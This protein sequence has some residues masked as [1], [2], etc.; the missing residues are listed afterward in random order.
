MPPT[1]RSS[2]VGPIN[3]VECF[4]CQEGTLADQWQIEVSGATDDMHAVGSTGFSSING[5][6]IADGLSSQTDTYWNGCTTVDSWGCGYTVQ[7]TPDTDEPFDDLRWDPGSGLQYYEAVGWSFW[8]SK[9]HGTI[10]GTVVSRYTSMEF[11]WKNHDGNLCNGPHP[12]LRY[13]WGT[14]PKIAFNPVFCFEYMRPDMI[15]CR[16]ASGLTLTHTSL[17]PGLQAE[18]YYVEGF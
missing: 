18:C 17:Y 15:D 5:V 3:Y 14:A 8:A 13:D 4:C 2:S 10:P 9:I 16:L 7:S 12:F 1:R 6:Y 11:W